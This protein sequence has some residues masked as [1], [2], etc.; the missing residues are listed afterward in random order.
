MKKVIFFIVLIMIYAQVLA[1]KVSVI[2]ICDSMFLCLK[3]EMFEGSRNG[4]LNHDLQP[5]IQTEDSS[6]YVTRIID[7]WGDY[8]VFFIQDQNK[9]WAEYDRLVYYE[10][11]FID[12]ITFA[13][14]KIILGLS[15]GKTKYNY[16][17]NEAQHW[18]TTLR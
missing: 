15:N 11:T 18:T 13:Q 5:F 3:G 9:R 4:I 6:L 10:N 1:Q 7:K 8:F 16:W 12:T 14:K 2:K 17:V